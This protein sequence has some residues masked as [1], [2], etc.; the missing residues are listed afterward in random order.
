MFIALKENFQVAYDMR[1]QMRQSCSFM[2]TS[3]FY[4]TSSHSFSLVNMSLTIRSDY[5]VH[6]TFS[7]IPSCILHHLKLI[8]FINGF[9]QIY[10]T[11][12]LLQQ[13]C[14]KELVGTLETE[15]SK[16]LELRSKLSSTMTSRS[17]AAAALITPQENW[18]AMLPEVSTE[19]CLQ[20][21]VL[22]FAF[23][24]WAI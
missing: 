12:C 1:C 8:S 20:F 18:S 15:R 3:Q 13:L 2:Q 22:F 24:T 23:S 4:T 11:L 14:E 21:A 6:T 9:S 7:L 10:I 5:Y 16:L 19:W 17:N